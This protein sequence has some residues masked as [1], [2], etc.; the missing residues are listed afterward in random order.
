VEDTKQL[1][2]HTVK[3]T[4]WNYT[5]F[6]ASKLLTFI[7]TIILARLLV[8]ADFGLLSMGL[9][10]IN[11]LD[12][13]N[14]LGVGPA[15][16]YHQGDLE[17]KSNVAFTMS[18][19]INAALTIIAFLVAPLV[20]WFFREPRVTPIIQALSFTFILSS[21]GSIHSTR[22]KKNLDFRR[23][24]IPE[25]GKTLFK[26]LVSI[27]MALL[28]FGVWSLVVGQIAGI[29]IS[30][31]LYW[32]VNP[33]RP[34]ICFDLKESR[35]LLNYGSQI[36]LVDLL[37]MIHQNIDYLIIGRRMEST[38]LGYYTMAFRI[39]ELI[40]INICHVVSKALFPAYSKIQ[41]NLTAL[42]T[43][44][45][46]TLGYVSLLTIPIGIGL[47]VLSDEFIRVFFS[48]KWAES[49]P[50]MQLLCLYA[51]IYSL[52]FNA[53]DIYKALGKPWILN[54]LGVVKLTITV[55][56][57]W[58]AAGYSI[59]TVAAAQLATN[60]LLTILK[61][62]IIGEII[63]VTAAQVIKTIFPPALGSVMMFI[64]VYFSKLQMNSL[65]DIVRIVVIPIIG[66]AVYFSTLW[67]THRDL[68]IST[69][70]F[71]KSSV[72]S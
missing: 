44:F 31:L 65:N 23:V 69:I 32:I 7:S 72:K 41:N 36:I 38:Q 71:A 35:S 18:V 29:L 50:V 51:V 3:S 66:I 57:L 30:N 28:G 67:F 47:Y 6:A 10:A 24:F 16:I 19:S 4:L 5:S 20:A 22:L 25:I 43:G 26:G 37:G 2:R 15:L 8:P 52:S 1:A 59:Y 49:I 33:W 63:K 70:Q 27:L 60:I 48:D 56:V 14:E 40:I 54:M 13:L 61:L 68:V 11:Y 62:V 12:M 45:L 55:P 58:I 34:K 39:P 42:Q 46:K 17:K 21:L 64:V 53:G 9:I